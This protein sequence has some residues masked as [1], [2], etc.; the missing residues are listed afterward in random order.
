M[1]NQ[2]A[3]WIRTVLEVV[4]KSN[5]AAHVQDFV[6]HPTRETYKAWMKKEKIRPMDYT[7]HGAPPTAHKPPEIDTS[8][9]H[10]EV[11]ERYKKR[12]RIEVRT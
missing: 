12:N 5:P 4:D 1:G 9:I 11:L 10:R 8:Q 6:K 7:E 3:P 2:D